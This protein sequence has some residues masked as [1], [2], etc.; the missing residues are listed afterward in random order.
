MHGF[1]GDESGIL[2]KRKKKAVNFSILAFWTFFETYRDEVSHF[3]F[4]GHSGKAPIL[5]LQRLSPRHHGFLSCG[6]DSQ[7]FDWIRES[8]SPERNEQHL[9]ETGFCCPIRCTRLIA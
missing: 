6:S 8:G 1:V 7:R 3:D 5:A 2:N 4:V 9:P